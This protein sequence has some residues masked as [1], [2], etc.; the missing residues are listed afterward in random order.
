MKRRATLFFMVA[1][2]QAVPAAAGISPYVRLAM[3]ANRLDM[4]A[5]NDGIHSDEAGLQ[6]SGL[7]VD[8]D[9][10]GPGIGPAGAVGLWLFPGLRVGATISQ[11]HSMRDN[12]V[13]APGY[14]YA[15]QYDFYITEVGGEM[16]VRL[17]GLAGLCFGGETARARVRGTLGYTEE[18]SSGQYYLD[19][20]ARGTATTYRAFIGIDQ[21]NH[22]GVAGFLRIGYRFARVGSLPSEGVVSDGSSSASF[23]DQTVPFDYSGYYV[24]GGIGF[25]LGRGLRA[26]SQLSIP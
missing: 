21:T 18:W 10:I 9:P 22:T 8:F 7:P 15:S 1:M 23:T 25:D 3:N 6:Q 5:I 4:A 26:R 14:F 2:L 19:A 20:S 12:R 16:V 13:H 24:S 17:Q 11:Q